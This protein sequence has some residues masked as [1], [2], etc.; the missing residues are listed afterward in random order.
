MGTNGCLSTPRVCSTA[1]CAVPGATTMRWP[2][3]Q[4]PP[5]RCRSKLAQAPLPAEPYSFR[6]VGD[7]QRDLVKKYI[8]ARTARL[9]REQ[10]DDT[11]VVT[12]RDRPFCGPGARNRHV[13]CSPCSSRSRQQRRNNLGLHSTSAWPPS[14]TRPSPLSRLSNR[15]KLKWSSRLRQAHRFAPLPVSP[16]MSA[17]DADVNAGARIGCRASCRLRLKSTVELS[18]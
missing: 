16:V 12:Q 13:T 15:R 3:W 2:C 17:P 6:V 18:S 4:S 10:L 8:L 9:L 7:M 1:R 14:R 5:P 11:A